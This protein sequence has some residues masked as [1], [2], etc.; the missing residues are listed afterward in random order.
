[1]ICGLRGVDE[2]V[3]VSRENSVGRS[4]S[5]WRSRPGFLDQE[6]VPIIEALCRTLDA[7]V[8]VSCGV[9]DS[10][11]NRDGRELRIVDEPPFGIPAL[12]R[13][14]ESRFSEECAQTSYLLRDRP[15]EVPV[16]RRQTTLLFGFRN[17]E[18][19][20]PCIRPCEL[21]LRS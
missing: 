4:W 17:F 10:L 3:V 12:V 5:R 6:S 18:T 8:S 20:E 13:L 2:S 1:M 15:F 16:E 7:V 21:L 11:I 9:Y 19:D 14:E